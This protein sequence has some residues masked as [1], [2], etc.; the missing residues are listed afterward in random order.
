MNYSIINCS[1]D[2]KD[3][4]EFMFLK[5]YRVNLIIHDDAYRKYNLGSIA[6]F[7][8][9]T[10]GFDKDADKVIL[11]SLGF[12]DS[13][14][15]FV[16]KQF[17][18]DKL[19]EEHLVLNA[20]RRELK[21]FKSWCSYN[22]MAFDEPFIKSR[23]DKNKIEFQIPES[24]IDLYRFI[25]PYHKQLGME[26]CNLKTV[27][28]YIGIEREDKIDGGMSVL[29]Y[30]K[31]LQTRDETVREIIMLH[32]YEDVLNLPRIFELV[33]K[34]EEECKLVREDGITEKQI[35][36]LRHLMAKKKVSLELDLQRISKKAAAR[37]IDCIIKDNYNEDLINAIINNSY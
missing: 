5:E 8:I 15:N 12:F 23:M 32:N 4:G 11:I 26:R 31:Y 36:Y 14:M 6:F 13:D 9:E 29:L 34:I 1:P 7:D 21:G 17:Y 28:K 24:H 18:A 3:N 10:T 35:K 22:G 37:I 33:Y 16:I 27:E 19:T 25:R 30:N 2:R 20:F